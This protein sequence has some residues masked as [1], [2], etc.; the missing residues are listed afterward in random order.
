MKIFVPTVGDRIML[1][2]PWTFA[3]YNED[4]N[5]TL[6]QHLYPKDGWENLWTGPRKAKNT[7]GPW[8]GEH[9]SMPCTLRKGV[10]IVFDRL[11]LAKGA[12]CFHS[13]TFIIKKGD[14]ILKNKRQIRFWA[15][16]A[17]V[18]QI[19]GDINPGGA[20]RTSIQVLYRLTEEPK[21]LDL[22]K[23]VREK[24]PP[25]KECPGDC[26]DLGS[27]SMA[28]YL[29]GIVT[30]TD[31]G[32]TIVLKTTPFVHRGKAYSQAKKLLSDYLA[33]RKL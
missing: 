12:V 21:L 30:I 18:N 17:E 2:K 25:R 19:E 15:K 7:F 26:H 29:T 1:S 4:R 20:L 31:K 33:K 27:S 5:L 22:L 8:S 11:Y 14:P 24:N 23:K 32:K 10:T 9:Q 13:V 3:L 28:G 6:L 16:L